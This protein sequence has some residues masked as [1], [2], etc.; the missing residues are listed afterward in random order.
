MSKLGNE[1]MRRIGRQQGAINPRVGRSDL[2]KLISEGDYIRFYFECVIASS[3]GSLD[4]RS[5][6]EK[7]LD[8]R[9]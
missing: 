3:E 9:R 4:C 5:N 7:L 6:S 1:L 2:E 8:T